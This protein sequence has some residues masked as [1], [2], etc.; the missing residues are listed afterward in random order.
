MNV[1]ISKKYKRNCDERS[2]AD[3]T[4]KTDDICIKIKIKPMMKGQIYKHK[5]KTDK[6]TDVYILKTILQRVF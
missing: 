1:I 6:R 3:I 5:T 2:H 4:K